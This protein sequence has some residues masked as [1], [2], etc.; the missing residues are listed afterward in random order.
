LP[1]GAGARARSAH[2]IAR[3]ALAP[4]VVPLPGGG[5][6][7]EQPVDARDVA[8]G[9]LAAAQDVACANG[10]ARSGRPQS[11]P[12][13]ELVRRAA[14]LRGRD[15][16]VLAVPVPWVRAALALKQ[17]WLGPGLSPAVLE[18]LLADTR[19]DPA[20]A[21]KALGIEL[22]PLDETLERTLALEAGR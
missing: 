14:R 10:A 9:V 16:R 19:F 4:F 20:P 11:L 22:R 1:A 2:A 15:P 13:R 6:N 8:D 18:V 3:E 12:A 21:A 7:L 5:V 17:R